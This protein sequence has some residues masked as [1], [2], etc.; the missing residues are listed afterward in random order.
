M[1]SFVIVWPGMSVSSSVWIHILYIQKSLHLG[2]VQVRNPAMHRYMH[3]IFT[4]VIGICSHIFTSLLLIYFPLSKSLGQISFSNMGFQ[5]YY[6]RCF[7][8]Q[9]CFTTINISKIN[10]MFLWEI[11]L[12]EDPLIGIWEYMYFSIFICFVL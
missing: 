3:K 1:E 6:F 12:S 4:Q 7:Y 2:D 5:V 11:Y 8:S 9:V 10:E